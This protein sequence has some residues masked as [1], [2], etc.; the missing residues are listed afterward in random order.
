V[1]DRCLEPDIF[2]DGRVQTRH[3]IGVIACLT[4][5]YLPKAS[6]NATATAQ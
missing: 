3:R 4:E 5:S 1:V 2:M 6:G